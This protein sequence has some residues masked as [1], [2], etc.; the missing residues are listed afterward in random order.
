M[1]WYIRT[2]RVDKGG[3]SSEDIS[4]FFPFSK[5]WINFVPFLIFVYMILVGNN[6]FS[7]YENERI[8]KMPSDI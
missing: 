7:V 2:G 4:N 5:I 1:Q 6:F 3:S 8:W